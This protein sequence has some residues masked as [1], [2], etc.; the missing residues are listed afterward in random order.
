MCFTNAL[1]A[2][3]FFSRVPDDVSLVMAGGYFAGMGNLGGELTAKGISKATGI[4]TVLD[5]YGADLSDSY[6]FGDSSND[7]EMIRLCPN[8]VAMGNGTKEVKEAAD[9]VT[10]HC[11]EDGIFH[12]LQ[13]YGLI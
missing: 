6:V 7:L 4:A 1:T 11:D 13:H 12:G 5:M 3:I 8:S 9:F 10:T 2:D